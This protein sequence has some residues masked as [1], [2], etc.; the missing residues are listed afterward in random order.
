VIPVP[1]TSTLNSQ[2]VSSIFALSA[3]TYLH[4]VVS[5]AYPDLNE[6]QQSVFRTMKVLVNLPDPGLLRYIVWLFC[7]TGCLA[8]KEIQGELRQL[9]RSAG[10]SETGA[11]G[12]WNS[13]QRN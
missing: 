9:A 1:A 2:V 7:V 4:T 8:S 5:G 10:A 11:K 3:I 13:L 6:I 12:F